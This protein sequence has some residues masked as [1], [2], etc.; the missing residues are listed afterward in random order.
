MINYKGKKIDARKI[1]EKNRDLYIKGQMERIDRNLRK[2][3]Y[4]T[5]K[6]INKRMAEFI[7]ALDAF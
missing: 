4:D 1:S 7:F 2:K 3:T 5:E 6:R